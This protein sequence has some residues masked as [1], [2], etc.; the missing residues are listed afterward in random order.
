MGTCIT[1]ITKDI[2]QEINEKLSPRF[3]D[4]FRVEE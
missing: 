4:H 3:Y 1:I 2:G